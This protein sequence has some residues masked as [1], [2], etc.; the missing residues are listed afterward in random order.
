LKPL[1]ELQERAREDVHRW[2]SEA[3]EGSTRGTLSA[4]MLRQAFAYA[5]EMVRCAA[6]VLVERAGHAGMEALAIASDGKKKPVDKLTFGQCVNLLEM[7]DAR[8]VIVPRRKT[9]SREDREL[10]SA[11]TRARNEFAHGSAVVAADGAL[12]RRTLENVR[13][14]SYLAIIEHAAHDGTPRRLA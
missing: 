8:N 13:K 7:L 6:N 3:E 10:L 9:I 12:V 1:V 14:L 4:G 11:L 2:M 5:E